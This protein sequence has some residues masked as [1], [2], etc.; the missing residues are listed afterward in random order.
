MQRLWTSRLWPIAIL[1]CVWQFGAQFTEPTYLPS[2]LVL[3]ERIAG[4]LR[5]GSPSQGPAY[6]VAGK[7]F[8]RIVLSALLCLLLGTCVGLLMGIRKGFEAA[9]KPVIIVL[10][11]FPTIVWAFLGVMWFGISDVTPVFATVIIVAPFVITNVWQ[12]AKAFDPDLTDMAHAYK[13]RDRQLLLRVMLPQLLPYLFASARI[14]FVLSW[15]IVLIGETFGVSNGVGREFTYWF[16]YI[17]ADMILAWGALFI[18]G[19]TAL[20][21]IVFSPI[22]RHVFRWRPSLA[23]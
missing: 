22:E 13:A 8:G 1:L 5:E 16:H 7:T 2:P 17:R 10:L 6:L 18:I 3:A 14:A 11:M 12:G 23:R 20:E 9:A 21:W 15:K 4:I 19:M